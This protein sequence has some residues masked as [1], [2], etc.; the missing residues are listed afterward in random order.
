M[1]PLKTAI[2]QALGDFVLRCTNVL[3]AWK[4][5]KK[6]HLATNSFYRTDADAIAKL[7]SARQNECE[8]FGVPLLSAV[9]AENGW[10]LFRFRSDALD[11]YAAALPAAKEPDDSYLSRRLWMYARHPDAPVPDDAAVLQAFF[12]ALFG[13]PDGERAFLASA[14]RLDGQA[15]ITLEQRMTRLAKILLYE[16]R[17]NT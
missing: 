8:C 2:E 14:R 11:A 17:N 4:P 3:P 15:R 10:L 16:R 5:S 13:L 12:A 7:L 6:A 1:K 9:E